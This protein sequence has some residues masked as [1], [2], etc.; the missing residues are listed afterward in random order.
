MKKVTTEH[1]R[2]LQEIERAGFLPIMRL[3]YTQ[4]DQHLITALAD[5]WRPE[6]ST[7][8]FTVGEMTI[9]LGDVAV[10]LGLPIEGNAIT[11]GEQYD[12]MQL[13]ADLLG[14]SP[15]PEVTW[16][17]ES[18]LDKWFRAQLANDLAVDA[19]DIQIAQRARAIILHIITSRLCCDHSKNRVSLKWLPF[20]ADLG[21]C[22]NY[23]WGS[24]VLCYT[25]KELSRLALQESRKLGGC[26]FLLQVRN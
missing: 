17:N 24:A 18:V 9:T 20:L 8:H 19:T 6:T 26:M 14:L 22:A 12:Y 13:C 11:I 15:P 7:F 1:P 3:R 25:Y 16:G 2:V 23:S 10:L 4:L 21:E 5:R